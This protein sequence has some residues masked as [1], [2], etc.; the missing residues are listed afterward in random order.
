MWGT[1]TCRG[2]ELPKTPVG[3]AEQGQGPRKPGS[4]SGVFIQLPRG[5]E[6]PRGRRVSGLSST[7][8]TELEIAPRVVQCGSQPLGER[9][10]NPAKPVRKDHPFLGNFPDSRSHPESPGDGALLP[11]TTHP[12]P[13]W[14]PHKS[15]FQGFIYYFFGCSG[16]G[17][18]PCFFLGITQRL[19]KIV[20]FIGKTILEQLLRAGGPGLSPAEMSQHQGMPNFPLHQQPKSF[21]TGP[22]PHPGWWKGPARAFPVPAAVG[23]RAPS[24]QAAAPSARLPFHNAGLGFYSEFQTMKVCLRSV[25]GLPMV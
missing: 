5:R 2:P 11:L 17:A 24:P 16:W 12:H 6:R 15:L 23:L 9:F 7:M 3:E 25:P 14:F 13:N 8:M 1:A 10:P 21:P 4:D 22:E 20:C 18:P 19:T